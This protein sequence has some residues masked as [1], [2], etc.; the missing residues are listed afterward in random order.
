MSQNLQKFAKFQNFQL[1]NVVDFEKCCKTH[2]FL[3]K[4]VPIQPKTSNILPKFCQPTLSDAAI[5]VQKGAELQASRG[6]VRPQPDWYGGRGAGAPRYDGTNFSSIL[7]TFCEHFR[8]H[9]AQKKR[10]KNLA[11]FRVY[12]HQLLQ[13]NVY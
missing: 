8:Q 1:E 7:A 9:L 10:K 6:W 13:V 2:I 12:R 3:Q 4:S 11:R 5:R